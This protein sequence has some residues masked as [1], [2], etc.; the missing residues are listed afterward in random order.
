MKYFLPAVALLALTMGHADQTAAKKKPKKG[1]A[2]LLLNKDSLSKNDYSKIVK[3]GV[4]KKGLFTVIYKAKDN[5]LYFEIPDSAFG[6]TYMLAN[7]IASTSNTKDYVAGQMVNNPMVI[8]LSKDARSVYFNLVQSNN[9]VDAND[10]ISASF[11]RNF[12]NPILKGFK[13]AAE[14]GKSVVIDVSAFFGTNEACISPIKSD[15]PIAK[16][17]GGGNS[18]KGTFVSDASGLN[19]VKAFEKN[20]EIKSTL[21][22]NLTGGLVAQPYS[23]QMHRSFF[24][25]P[26][27]PMPKRYQD[28]RVGYFSELQ[29]LYSSDKD[30]VD[31]RTFIERWRIEPKDED[32]ARY[33]RGEL[34]EPKKKIVFYVD[35]AFPD[36][37][38]GTIKEGILEWNRAF[39]AAGFKN[40]V[41]ARDYPAN[42]SLF[43]PDD[44]RYNCFKYATTA[45]PNAMGPSHNDPRTGEILCADVLW[46]HN[47]LSLLHNWRFVQTGAVDPRVRKNVFDD[48]VMRESIKYAASHE[49]GHTLGLMHNMGASY[50]YPVDSLRSPSFTQK[51]GTTPS[52][53]DYARNNY[54]AQPGDVERGVNLLPPALGVYD[55]YAINWGYRLI[56]GAKTPDEEKPVLDKWIAAKAADPMYEFGAQQMLGII[57]PT[58]LTEDLGNDHL[59]A[60]N[61]AISNMKILMKNLFQWTMEKGER[62][63]HIEDVYKEVTR[64]YSRYIG[65][66]I[67]LVGGIEYK[68]VRQGDNQQTGRRFIPRDQQK[69]AMLWLLNQARTYDSWLTPAS[70]INKMDIDMNVNDKIRTTIVAS[71]LNGGTLY[72]IK[73]GGNFNPTLNYPIDTYLSDLTNALFVAPKGGR[74]SQ[75]EQKLEAAAVAQMIKASGLEKSSSKGSSSSD[76][77]IAE[78]WADVDSPTSVCGHIHEAESFSRINLGAAALSQDELGAIMMGRL[79]AALAKFRAYR[80]TAVG[81]TRDFYNYQIFL[82]ERL[83]TNK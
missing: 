46:Y 13:I 3:D 2:S 71:L 23:V 53:M 56:E 76:K 41:E 32:R 34:V 83:L 11:D 4:K 45:T 79:R 36:K 33:F 49:V 70:V 20:I 42:D 52:I 6:K 38:R 17:L 40:V 37:W 68:E 64:Q 19:E 66:V 58:D 18:L 30:R 39:E 28:N 14:N 75:A 16:L 10:P 47:I 8:K 82:I 48:D 24:V 60:G 27:D 67:P 63:D 78:F 29:N 25:L 9:M 44:M 81:G 73:D 43:D 31:Q 5:K 54:V 61:L 80:G 21:T 26:D 74:L 50:S 22:F 65:H 35:S 7:R 57:D 12:L 51:Y 62:Y 55:I 1:M 69:A 15:S 77:G 72:R 59:K